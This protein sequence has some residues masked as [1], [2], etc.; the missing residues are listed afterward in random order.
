MWQQERQDTIVCTFDK[1]SPKISA[2]DIHEWIYTKLK[3]ESEDVNTLQV[4]GPRRQVFIKVNKPTLIDEILNI[5]QGESSYQHDTGE[6][7]KVTISQAGLG[8]RIV[9]VA[10]LPP[11]L[12]NEDIRQYMTKYGT[13]LTIQDEK[14][15]RNYR[16]TVSN[17]V[18]LIHMELNAHVPKHIHITGHRALVTYMGQPTTCYICNDTTH[19]A[20]ECPTRQNKRRE[21]RKIYTNTWAN[22]VELGYSTTTNNDTTTEKT[23][24]RQATNNQEQSI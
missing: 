10:N 23:D 4:D 7:S 2:F 6:I 22:I 14:W 13:V 1:N 24:E 15:S 21:G 5:T 12:K 18:R 20:T 16:Y 3:L 19:V 8:K 17:G 11:E 9:R